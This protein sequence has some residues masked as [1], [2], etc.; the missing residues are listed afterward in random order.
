MTD[1]NPLNLTPVDWFMFYGSFSSIFQGVRECNMITPHEAALMHPTEPTAADLNHTTF[2]QNPKTHLI[3]VTK[4]N[5]YQFP[6]N[7]IITPFMLL[8]AVR[9]NGDHAAASSY[10]LHELMGAEIPYVRI[11]CDYY[12]VIEKQD[13]YGANQTQL[14]PWKKDE[15]KQDHHKSVLTSIPKFDDYIIEPN[16]TT[17]APV[18]RNCYNLYSRFP[19][20]PHP[21]PTTPEQFPV[22]YNFLTHIFSN[23]TP[24][25]P[26]L[27]LG[28]TYLKVLYEHP[29]QQ[30]PILCLISKQRNTGKTTFNNWLNM[31][32]G[33]NYI[34][35]SPEALT[36][37][38][39]SN[40]ATKNVI[41]FEE[42][43]VEKQAGIEKL[44]HL[45]TGKSIDVSQKFVSE[46]S[47]PFYGKFILFSNKVLDF[48]RIDDEEIRF[49]IRPIPSIIGKRNTQIETQLFSEIPAFLR[50]LADLPPIDFD[51]GS[52]MV[53]DEKRIVTEALLAVK[54]ESKSWLYKEL[55]LAIE[56]FFNQNSG[57]DAFKASPIDIKNEWFRNDNKVSASYIRKVLQDEAGIKPIM[58]PTSGGAIKYH[59]FGRDKEGSLSPD[60]R[61]GFPYEF[62]RN[63]RV[64]DPLLPHNLVEKVSF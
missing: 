22:T 58:S 20:T 6:V 44:K 10:I 38:F 14:V 4:A 49:W 51:N 46:Y 64:D 32:F 59:R 31:I 37:Q 19:H 54:A 27:D 55:E 63:G 15:I 8:S 35:I 33:N 18:I 36:K 28:L 60:Y 7:A 9:F 40:Y 25:S 30:L 57:I 34:S 62:Y 52:R 26:Q 41:T 23:G 13:R 53:L 50:Y 42:A 12:K 39:N 48:M 2:K 11:K 17:Y 56:D 16:N 47:I 61:T 43:F 45:S 21:T 29:K 24:D 5:A 1:N 3:T